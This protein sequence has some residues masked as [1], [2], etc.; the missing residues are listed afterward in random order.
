M[1]KSELAKNKGKSEQVSQF[2]QKNKAL[3]NK[4]DLKFIPWSTID[5]YINQP[6]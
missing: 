1:K 5:Q 3:I 6:Q 4:H 2:I